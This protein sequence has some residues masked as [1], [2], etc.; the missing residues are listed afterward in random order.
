MSAV[1]VVQRFIAH[2]NAHDVAG[3]GEDLALD[4]VFVDSLGTRVSG[5]DTL[6]EAWRAYLAMVPDYQLVVEKY[7]EDGAE[8]IVLG[9]AQGTFSRD[10]SLQPQDAWV[11]PGAF[12]ARIA[13]EHIA[14]WQVYADNEPIRRC[15]QRGA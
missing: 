11:T 4:H 13:G 2:I 8:V 3:I 15:M 14:F 5:R 10:G 1:E 9:I 7:F 6:R 12:H